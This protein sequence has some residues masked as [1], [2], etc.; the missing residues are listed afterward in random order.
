VPAL[1]FSKLTKEEFKIC[2]DHW[3][4][5]VR[6]YI[7]YRCGDPE[8]ATDV[9]QE[10]FLKIWEKKIEFQE[11]RTKGLL[12]KIANELWISQYRKSVSAKKYQFSFALK[13]KVLEGA[14]ETEDQLYYQELKAK[15]ERA[16][17]AMPEKRR[18]VFLMSRMDDL[19]YQEI[20]ERLQVSAKAV[21][22]RMNLALKDLRKILSHEK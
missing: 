21:E 11:S 18:V 15:Y 3:F 12:Y 8:L 4:D 2:F 17:A 22:K 5:E 7:T 1:N 14:N 6:N 20:A 19:T 13:A 10:A 16:L 9:A